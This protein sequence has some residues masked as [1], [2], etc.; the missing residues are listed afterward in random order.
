MA[1][2]ARGGKGSVT[3]RGK[4]RPSAARS[5][6]PPAPAEPLP[7]AQGDRFAAAGEGNGVAGGT[8]ARRGASLPAWVPWT[9]CHGTGAGQR[10]GLGTLGRW[11]LC[12][13]RWGGHSGGTQPGV[14]RAVPGTP[15]L[16]MGLG[17]GERGG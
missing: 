15:S 7:S 10:R 6:Q 4:A 11:C 2:G 8:G 16:G 5:S 17:R 12:P 14:P 9:R 13:G 1:H 3:T